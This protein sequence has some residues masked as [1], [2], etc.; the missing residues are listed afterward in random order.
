MGNNIQQRKRAARLAVAFRVAMMEDPTD[1]E[2]KA[3][4]S[5]WGQEFLK[6]LHEAMSCLNAIQSPMVA[7]ALFEHSCVVFLQ[8]TRLEI[9]PRGAT[10]NS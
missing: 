5:S 7:C 10:P 6:L 1:Y 2:P 9:G 4:G 3:R 8:G